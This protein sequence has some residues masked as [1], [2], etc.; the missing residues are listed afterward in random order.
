[1][2]DNTSI[3]ARLEIAIEEV[4]QN[5]NQ[6][7]VR[8]PFLREVLTALKAQEPRVMTLE[9]V[10]ELHPGDDVYI[11]RISSITGVHYIYA[12]T[13][14]RV[15]SKSIKLCPDNATLWFSEHGETW[16]CWTSRPTDAQ[17]EEEPWANDMHKRSP[18]EM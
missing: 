14:W 8:T 3:V 1:M 9:E 12:A 16:R 13:M 4:E 15:V 11:E 5:P 10:K 17:R 6:F 18:R 2:V 7:Y